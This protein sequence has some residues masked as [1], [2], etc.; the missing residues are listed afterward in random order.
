LGTLRQGGKGGV[1]ISVKLQQNECPSLVVPANAGTTAR[2]LLPP[3]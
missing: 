2:I 3:S 1:L